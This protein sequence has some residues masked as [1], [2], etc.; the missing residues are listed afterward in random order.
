MQRLRGQNKLGLFQEPKEEAC[1][2]S[3]E[4]E[5]GKGSE[6]PELPGHERNVGF[7]LEAR[8]GH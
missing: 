4:G 8:K 5:A 6:Y 7:C 3:S 2:C 1:G